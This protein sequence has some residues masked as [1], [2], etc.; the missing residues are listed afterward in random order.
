MR[1]HFGLSLVDVPRTEHLLQPLSAA[2]CTNGALDLLLPPGVVFRPLP[3]ELQLTFLAGMRRN[4]QLPDEIIRLILGFAARLEIPLQGAQDGARVT[5]SEYVHSE[6][7]E[8]RVRSLRLVSCVPS[9]RC[10]CVQAKREADAASREANREAN[11]AKRVA[12]E[13]QRGATRGELRAHTVAQL[14]ALCAQQGLRKT[15]VKEELVARLCDVLCTD[16]PAAK[17]RRTEVRAACWLA[18]CDG[19]RRACV[20]CFVVRRRSRLK[21]GYLCVVQRLLLHAARRVGD[22]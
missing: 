7:F 19:N 16:E 8:P 12:N 11:E 2:D 14:K 5:L 4:W 20:A 9:S 21:V 15:G 10:V 18:M 3:R 22:G 6:V 13:A 1:A 17:L